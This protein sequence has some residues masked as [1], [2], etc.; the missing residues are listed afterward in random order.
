MREL[1]LLGLILIAIKLLSF[2]L[3]AKIEISESVKD[4]RYPRFSENGFIE[5]VLR[6]QSGTYDESLIAVD[7]FNLRLYSTDAKTAVMC[8]VLSDHAILDTEAGV[9]YSNNQISIKGD[10][11]EIIGFDWIWNSDERFV[12]IK[13]DVQVEF[14]QGISSV[15]STSKNDFGTSIKS[16][17]LR[18]DLKEDRYLFNFKDR[19]LLASDTLKLF[20]NSLQLESLNYSQNEMDLSA[21]SDFSSLVLIEGSGNAE[22]LFSDQRIQSDSFEILPRQENAFFYD[23]AVLSFNNTRLEGDKIEVNRS[24]IRVTSRE[25]I[26][27]CSLSI[28]LAE[29]PTLAKQSPAFSRHIYIQSKAIDLTKTLSGYDFIFQDEVFYKSLS[30]R[31]F[32]NWLFVQTLE[33]LLENTKTRIQELAYSEA[34]GSVYM[35]HVNYQVGAES[36]KHFPLENRLELTGLVDFKSDLASIES[37]RLLIEET[38]IQAFKIENRVQVNLPYSDLFSFDMSIESV[39]SVDSESTESNESTLASSVILADEVILSSVEDGYDC[40]FSKSVSLNRAN[41][42]MLS[43]KLQINWVRS[44][45]LLSGFKVNDLIAEQSVQLSQN[46]FYATSDTVHMPSDSD[47]IE[48]IGNA[49]MTD[50]KG[51][52]SGE[53]IVFNRSNQQTSIFGS[54]ESG[55]RAKVQFDLFER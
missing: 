18:L 37:D 54:K 48:L 27:Y 16:D 40:Y 31:L 1:N 50:Q 46:H 12:E 33:S 29:D 39:S 32:S 2:P 21:M 42:N 5:W 25:K 11:F 9:S 13:A 17:Y 53:R 26:D 41:F 45:E 43:D 44:D 20:S 55:Q 4:F 10:G 8:E 36:M 38:L 28:E 35:E 52:V 49:Q 14:D 6:G 24:N 51:S 23:N 15:F 30:F 22:A 3:W 7:A 34:K 47:T 19:V